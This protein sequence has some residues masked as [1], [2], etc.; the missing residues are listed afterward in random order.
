MIKISLIGSGNVAQHL[1]SA[2]MEADGIELVQVFSRQKNT[3]S[4]LINESKIVTNLNALQPADIYIISITDGAIAEVSSKLPFEGRLVAHTSGSLPM[5]ALDSKN[6]RA[7]FYPLQTFSKNKA[8]DFNDIPICL[9]SE[10]T[11]DFTMLRQTAEAI[12]EIT[13][14]IDSTQR[15]AIHVSAVFVNN[16][17][18]HLYKIAADICVEHSIPFE[19]LKPLITETAHKI[20][21]LTPSEAQ[22][23][24][25]KRNDQTTI[26]AHLDML[27]NQNQQD[28]YKLLT[29]S[30]QTYE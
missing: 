3:L 18:N 8:V 25:A 12:S 14:A 29:Q 23:G 21:V 10:Y 4:H 28:I 7:V 17:V 15:K 2:F 13:F 24:P 6:H 19:I 1:I 16:F 26:S 27:T 5:T 9:E 30:I 11:A 22:T 20:L